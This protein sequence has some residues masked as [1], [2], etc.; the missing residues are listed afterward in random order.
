MAPF[1]LT[2]ITG[3]LQYDLIFLLIGMGFGAALELTG[4]GDTRKIVSQ[5]YLR[6]ADLT[7]LK[8]MFT[9]IIVAATLIFLSS[10]L[11]IVDVQR[12]WV[13]PTYLWP[14]IVGGLLIG[15]GITIGGFCPGTSL[16]AAATL[17]VDGIVFLAGAA[18]GIFLFGETVSTFQEFWLS[19]FLGS[20]TLPELFGLSTGTTLILLVLMA[21]AMFFGGELIEARF[22]SGEEG[23]SRW[24]WRTPKAAAAGGLL[25]LALLTAAIGQP[26]SEDR[27]RRIAAEGERQLSGREVFVHPREVVDLRRNTALS[28]A[29]L[30]LRDER[31]FNLFHIAGSRRIDP[32]SLQD[33]AVVKPLLADGDNVIHLLVS[34]GDELAAD[35]WKQLKARGVLNLYVIDGGINHWLEIYRPANCIAERQDL[36]E[37]M[38]DETPVHRFLLAVGDRIPQA[39]PDYAG[40]DPLPDCAVASAK[41]GHHESAG[42]YQKKVILQKKAATKGGC[43]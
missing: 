43:G 31:E 9:A 23:G 33:P 28:V 4:F 7:V 15:A 26:T 19:S 35:A 41:A 27:W 21:F 11:G 24:S 29:V 25:A 18:A 2:S 14:G 1:N 17:K 16:V 40:R 3:T 32:A 42:S 37:G 36:P 6:K 12:L 39:H 13:N 20:F 30:D 5:F 34:T 10:A 22:R 8:A 38:P